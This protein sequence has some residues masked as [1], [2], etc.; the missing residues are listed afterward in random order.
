MR[1]LQVPMTHRARIHVAGAKLATVDRRCAAEVPVIHGQVH[2]RKPR[3]P[4]QRSKAAPVVIA[5][6]DRAE[7]S[8][9]PPSP[10]GMETIARTK[11]QPADPTPAA[12]SKSE[13]AAEAEERNVSRRPDRTIERISVSR[14][15]P[16]R[17]TAIKI[18]PA[19]VVIRS[20]SPVVGRNPGPSPIR[21]IDPT[22]IAIRS[23][24]SR[25]VWPPHLTIVRDFGPG[26][27][28]IEI[29]GSDVIVVSVPP[30]FRITDHGVAIGVPLI[31]IVARGCFANLVLRVGASALNGD[32]LSL[33]HARAALRSRYFNFAFAHQHFG[34]IVGTNQNAKAGFAPLGAKS[35][36]GRIDLGVGI[37]VFVDGVVRHAASQLNLDLRARELRDVGLGM[38][39]EPERIGVV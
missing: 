14:T 33:P 32:E 26:A 39:R 24:A 5:E 37:A 1:V 9:A 8:A 7:A 16:P 35:D 30:R 19:A 31:P 17:P 11:R 18:H 23:P 12:E 4:V 10:P 28:A 29:F 2:V 25:F 38:L 15:G 36:V 22:A 27:V 6:P 13:S 3:A 21:L 34:V 20:P